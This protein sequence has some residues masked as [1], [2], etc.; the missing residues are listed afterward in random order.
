MVKVCVEVREGAARFRV[1]VQAD[2]ISRAVSI[3]KGCRPG[4][5]V[6]VVYPIDPE[7]FFV[8]GPKKAGAGAAESR[9]PRPLHSPST[10]V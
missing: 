9:Q 5:D 7:E 10:R 3:M 6:R 2:S 8:A 4:R 1:A